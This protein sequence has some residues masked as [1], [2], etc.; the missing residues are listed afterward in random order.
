MHGVHVLQA[1]HDKIKRKALLGGTPM[2]EQVQQTFGGNFGHA[3]VRQN[4]EEAHSNGRASMAFGSNA[5]DL[6]AVV[7][8]MEANGVSLITFS[9]NVPTM[10]CIDP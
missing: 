9:Q 10:A 4:Q 1:Q 8:G 5:I 6:G 3:G 2:N 7:G